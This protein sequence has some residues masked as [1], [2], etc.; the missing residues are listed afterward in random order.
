MND[1]IHYAKNDSC[2]QLH[3]FVINTKLTLGALDPSGD[4][5]ILRVWRRA[6][7]PTCVIARC[8][9]SA[10]GLMYVARPFTLK[11]F[12]FKQTHYL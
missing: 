3:H 1:N 9:R 6:R 10:C 7:G 8:L 12:N 11:V 5:S 2:M 4:R